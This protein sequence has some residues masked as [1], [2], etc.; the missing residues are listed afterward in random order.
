MKLFKSTKKE[1]YFYKPEK[2]LSE[3]ANLYETDK[4]TEDS[5]NLSWG[6]EY[7]DHVCMHYT[8]IYE[9]YMKEKREEGVSIL[10]IGVCD[11]RF[12]YASIKMWM[13]YFKNPNFYAMDNFW[14]NSLENKLQ[15]IIDLNNSGVNFIY[16]DQGSFQDWDKIID[17]NLNKFDYIIEDGSHWPNHMMISLWKSINIMKSGGYYFMEDI[18]NPLKSRG[19]YKYDNALIGQELLETLSTKKLESSFLNDKQNLYIQNNLELVDL[20]LDPNKISYLAVLR[21]K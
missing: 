21:K 18:Q 2:S 5:K 13:S 3:L 10:E 9:K 16:S 19:L 14:A 7:K 6:K 8:T 11:K 15:D 1:N 12:P 17:L 4:G 20:I